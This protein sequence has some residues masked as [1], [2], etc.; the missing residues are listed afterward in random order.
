[1]TFNKIIWPSVGADLS[2][3]PPM[4]RLSLDVPIS[5]LIRLCTSSAEKRIIQMFHLSI[6]SDTQHTTDRPQTT[7]GGIPLKIEGVSKTFTGR[8]GAVEAL[9]QDRKSTRLNSSH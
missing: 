9:Q 4:Y 2:R 7:P 6:L 5:R 1:M 3:P 8:S